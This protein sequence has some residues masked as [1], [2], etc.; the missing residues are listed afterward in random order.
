[1]FT[2]E[3]RFILDG[4]DGW[5]YYFHDL[6]KEPMFQIKRQIKGGGIMIW[7]GI[8]CKGK[9]NIHFVDTKLKSND[10]VKLIDE[11]IVNIKQ[12]CGDK[13]IFQQDNA[14]VHTNKVVKNYFE[15]NNIKVLSWPAR[16]PDLNIIENVWGQVARNVYRNGRQY[17]SVEELKIVIE[18]A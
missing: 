10:Y 8:T 14:S 12:I 4:P 17:N 2:D 7:G 13:F 9:T 18:E 3:K 15:R 16:S 11:E 1:M 6:R 5:S